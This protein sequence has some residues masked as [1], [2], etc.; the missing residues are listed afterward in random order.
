[1]NREINHRASLLIPVLIFLFSASPLPWM[2][3][4][5]GVVVLPALLIVVWG[6]QA[7]S[8]NLLYSAFVLGLIYDLYGTQPFGVHLFSF[9]G[10][11]VCSGWV[12]T[13]WFSQEENLLKF[14]L[15]A[16]GLV[17]LLSVGQMLI[18]SVPFY[19]GTSAGGRQAAEMVL[20]NFVFAAL[21]AHPLRTLLTARSK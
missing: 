10:L 9:V 13:H 2:L 21:A 19:V 1:M 11:A 18:F 12:R 16:G 3:A 20:F 4:W 7:Y 14:A 8:V 17:T 6:L 5:R 15:L